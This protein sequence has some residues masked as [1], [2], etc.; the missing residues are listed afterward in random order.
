MKA[1]E[2]LVLIAREDHEKLD[3]GRTLAWREALPRAIGPRRRAA[4]GRVSRT[5]RALWF[6]PSDIGH[7][8]RTRKIILRRNRMLWTILVIVV[9]VLVV[10]A[11]VG[12]G[13]LSR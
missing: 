11:L 9:V 8:F 7:H 2:L 13:R 6:Y 12:R 3:D 5:T 10:L 4:L 1:A